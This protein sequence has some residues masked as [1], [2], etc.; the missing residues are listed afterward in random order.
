MNEQRVIMAEQARNDTRMGNK[1]MGS[2]D[3]DAK[4]VFIAIVAYHPESEE[5]SRLEECLDRLGKGIS[6]GV[7]ANDH[8]GEEA[9][10]RLSRSAAVFIR[11]KENLGYGRAANML[12]REMRCTPE[13]FCIINTDVNWEEGS[14]EKAIDWLDRNKNV[15]LAV[16]K[17]TDMNGDIEYLC[18]R[19]PTVLAMI[20]RRFIPLHMKPKILK[21]Y[22]DWYRMMDK[23]YGTCFEADY[24][25]GCFM[26]A[27]TACYA[28]I[29]GFDEDYFLYLEDADL[30][31]RMKAEG[32]TVHLPFVSVQH[33]WGKGN[34]KKLSLTIEN[35]KSC[36]IYFRKWGLK[37]I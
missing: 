2:R 18:K 8:K 27:R 15:S 6:Y 21:K 30:T 7:L 33:M 26:I 14:I 35:I 20:S 16:P 4:K 9:V 28:N 12:Y 5:V 25:S 29:G 37:V 36:I 34:Y 22:D 32:R 11:S 31:R 3:E 10:D 19:D 13:Y 24:L 17:I 1:N 23:D